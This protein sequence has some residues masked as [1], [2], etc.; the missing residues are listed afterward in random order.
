MPTLLTYI[1]LTLVGYIAVFVTTLVFS[2]KIKDFFAGVP[3]HTRANLYAIEAGVLAKVKSYEAELI[4]TIIPTP[5]TVT[6]TPAP[7]APV[8]PASALAFAPP[9]PVAPVA[10]AA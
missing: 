3:S 2:Q 4:G 10:P 5:A 7:A 1:D 8:A 6:P 9:A